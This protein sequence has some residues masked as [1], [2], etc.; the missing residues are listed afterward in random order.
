MFEEKDKVSKAVY[1]D[2]ENNTLRV[3]F[4]IDVGGM[5]KERVE[6]II[7]DF[8]LTFK[9]IKDEDSSDN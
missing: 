8:N 9:D 2:G 3:V 5:S 1:Y 4:S 6:D 7:K